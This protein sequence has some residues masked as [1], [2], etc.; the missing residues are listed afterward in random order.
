MFKMYRSWNMSLTTNTFSISQYSKF[1]FKFSSN[2]I[3]TWSSYQ[4]WKNILM[5]LNLLSTTSNFF[6]K[7]LLKKSPGFPIRI[8]TKRYSAQD[9]SYRW[10]YFE[11]QINL[12]CIF[13]RHLQGCILGSILYT[14]DLSALE[15]TAV[16]T[17]T[18]DSAPHAVDKIKKTLLESCE[19]N[20]KLDQIV[21][22]Y[23]LWT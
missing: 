15:N 5:M 19:Y 22:D 18:D 13:L 7:L 6:E 11:G 14:S 12:F 23:I 21:E 1:I 17:L 16:T 20:G 2:T 9:N 10:M 8:Q 4:N 3:R